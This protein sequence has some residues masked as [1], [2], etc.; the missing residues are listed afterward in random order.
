MLPEQSFKL[1]LKLFP[2][3]VDISFEEL[4]NVFGFRDIVISK[5]YTFLFISETK[6]LTFDVPMMKEFNNIPISEKRCTRLLRSRHEPE[7]VE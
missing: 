2:V 4:N 3:V 6:M 1:V 5:P 7:G